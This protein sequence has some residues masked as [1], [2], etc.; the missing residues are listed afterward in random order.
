MSCTE[1]PTKAATMD[2]SYQTS[3]S[4]RE[5][6]TLARSLLP[7]LLAFLNSG[8]ARDQTRLLQ[9]RP[10][11]GVV[12]HQSAGDTVTNCPRLSRRT[13]AVY[14]DQDVEFACRLRQLQWLA[15]NHA[16][17][18]IGEINFEGATIDFYFAGA[19]P[20]INASG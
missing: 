2:L 18:F 19:G 13:T 3:L 4:F 17:S 11:V 9:S 8:I 16:Q 5:L 7:V 1:E 6:E 10:Q 12:F 15:D 14:I 20:Q